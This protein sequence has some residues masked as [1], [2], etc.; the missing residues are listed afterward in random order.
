VEE[1]DK[2][3]LK[4][5]ACQEL[6]WSYDLHLIAHKKAVRLSKAETSLNTKD[7]VDEILEMVM[8]ERET[9]LR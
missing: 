1:L 6:K 7:A 3:L 4:Q 8:E 9:S 2:Y 5:S